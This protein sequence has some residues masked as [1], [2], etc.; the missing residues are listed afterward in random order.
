MIIY[1]NIDKANVDKEHFPAL[2]TKPVDVSGAGD[3]M[4][5]SMALAICSGASHFE[6]SLIGTLTS[7]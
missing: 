4:L 7:Y 3:S 2:A 1:N 6:A 5:A